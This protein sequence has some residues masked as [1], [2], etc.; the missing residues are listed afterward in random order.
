MKILCICP[1]GIGNYLLCYPAFSALKRSMPGSPVHMLALR[2][3]VAALARGDALWEKVHMF[4]PTKLYGNIGDVVQNLVRLRGEKYD[5]CLNYFPSN[6]WQYNLLP[7]ILGIPERYGFKYH[8]APLSKLSFLCT[9]KLP[10]APHLHDVRQNL[11][12]TRFFIKKDLRETGD[13]M[14]FPT[15]F[16][17]SD[18]T[19]AM[20][21]AASISNNKKFVG[22]HPGSSAEHGMA[23]KRWPSGAFAGLADKACGLL[24]A[25]ALIF[26][27]P[28]EA[29]VVRKCAA[30]MKTNAHSVAPVSIRRI[31]ALMS[32]CSVCVCNDSG[33]MHIAACQG[34]PT[35][36]IFGPTDEKRNGPVG[37][38]VLVIRKKMEGFPVWTALN[39]GDRSLPQGIDARASLVALSV[40]EAWEQLRPWLVSV[41]DLPTQNA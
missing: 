15:L 32:L 10:V 20:D 25:E 38:Q 18:R 23:A 24:G 3:G 11:A 14:V 31:A 8:F 39:V 17:P 7:A 6:T 27:S 5:A 28:D 41:A 13:E 33:L 40:D 2:E 34:T 12:L 35:V 4:D 26:G 29:A 22:L 36:G 9:R 19:W 30:S 21:Y 16:G 37:G 1:I